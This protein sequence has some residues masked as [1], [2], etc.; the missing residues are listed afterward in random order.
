[1]SA[2]FFFL[3][4]SETLICVCAMFVPNMIVF[5]LLTTLLYMLMFL[6]FCVR[7]QIIYFD[8]DQ[9]DRADLMRYYQR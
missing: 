2:Q 6:V 9:I 4:L 7:M 5:T 8:R 1:M 3:L